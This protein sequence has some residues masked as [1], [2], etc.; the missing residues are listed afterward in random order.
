VQL[1]DAYGIWAPAGHLRVQA[2]QFKAPQSVEELLEE[3]DIK[4]ATRSILSAG[5]AAPYAYAA[6]GLSIGR[7]LG[8]GV[9]TDRIPLG[10]RGGLTAQLAVMNGNGA[11]QLYNDAPYPSAMGRIAY[12]R[13]GFGLGVWGAFQPR[14]FGD[15]PRV[16]RDNVFTGGVD[17]TYNR[18]PLHVMLLAE[19]R[20]TRH[21]TTQQPDERGL[22]LSGEVAWRFGFIEPAV[23]VSYLDPSDKIPTD[24]LLYT[25][26]GVN[27]YVPGAPGRL[28]IDYTHRAEDAGRE[29]TNDGLELSAQVRF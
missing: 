24:A 14:A 5:V 12:D 29:L 15:Q 27:L 9:G 25:T 8:I 18:G 28:T 4:F 1:K 6:D 23:R 19:V 10:E 17:A 3:T 20:N 22:G 21:V 2:G 11:D 16:Y 13:S 7:Q 26:V